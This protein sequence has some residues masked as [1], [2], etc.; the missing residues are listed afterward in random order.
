V[1]AARL[2]WRR[3][4]T[5]S[6]DPE[7]LERYLLGYEPGQAEEFRF[8]K[9][10]LGAYFAVRHVAA[11]AAR[12]G[13]TL[14][15]E[16]RRTDRPGPPDA[17]E[18]IEVSF[19]RFDGA[20]FAGSYET[21]AVELATASPCALPVPGT[22]LAG[23]AE[24]APLGWYDLRVVVRKDGRVEG[25]LPGVTFRA[26]RWEGPDDMMAALGFPSEGAPG[27]AS[28]DVELRGA[29][30]VAP[31]ALDRSDAAFEAALDRI[32]LGG[33]PPAAE[34]RV[35]LLW[36][37]E[38][39]DWLCLGAL[40]ESPEPIERARRCAVTDAGLVTGGPVA[41]RPTLTRWS[42]R[43]GARLLLLASRAFRPEPPNP[44]AGGPPLLQL[45]LRERRPWPLAP[46][47]RTGS[48]ALPTR[49]A[50]AEEA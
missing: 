44:P 48:L 46:R 31:P 24:L 28:G 3:R 18:R 11:L 5:E 25:S 17:L 43:A 6:F 40:V 4:E 50:F 7:M 10:R 33:L 26:S 16:L 41:T 15:M 13:F 1:D 19:V 27:A 2:W 29:G 8:R 38:G 20:H 21:Y 37:L 39:G 22:T 14:G 42:D 23:E 34:P 32:G 49:P 12:Y 45:T 36:R 47:E 35:S 30:A 9:G